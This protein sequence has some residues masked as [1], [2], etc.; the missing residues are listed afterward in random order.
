MKEYRQKARQNIWVG[1][2]IFIGILI[3]SILGH[4]LKSE[5]IIGP[6]AA[7][8]GLV[9]TAPTALTARYKN[10]CLGHFIAVFIGLIM[11]YVFGGGVFSI[12]IAGAL[13]LLI[14]EFTKNI[15]P[16]ACATAV[17]AVIGHAKILFMMDIMIGVFLLICVAEFFNNI[18][19]IK[20]YF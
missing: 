12:A 3:I 7:S 1:L 2:K 15:H 19:K 17:I 14:M 20:K 9:F 11:V 8:C 6:L 13:A 4:A 5:L 18:I 10:I 16:P